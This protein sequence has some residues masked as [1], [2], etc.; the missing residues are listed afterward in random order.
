MR[1]GGRLSVR[2]PLT[3]LPNRQNPTNPMV[4]MMKVTM[5]MPTF[6]TPMVDANLLGF[7]ISNCSGNTC[8]KYQTSRVSNG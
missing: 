8:E 7:F 5:V 6:N 1:V 3:S 4:N 2:L